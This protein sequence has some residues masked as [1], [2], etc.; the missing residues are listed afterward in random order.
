MRQPISSSFWTSMPS[1]CSK[2]SYMRCAPPPVAMSLTPLRMSCI[3]TPL[4]DAERSMSSRR[5]RMQFSMS[6]VSNLIKLRRPP[7]K[8]AGRDLRL[9]R[10][11]WMADADADASCGEPRMAVGVSVPEA[12]GW[13]ACA[14]GVR[15][16]LCAPPLEEACRERKLLL[17][18]F[19]ERALGV[20]EEAA[21]CGKGV[22]RA[23]G[24]PGVGEEGVE[25]EERERV[26]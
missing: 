12:M 14:G 24:E 5:K 15:K 16:P 26:K 9:R 17:L 2:R 3:E 20:D 22:E 13:S 6:L 7:G 11:E 18:V 8:A 21:V 1:S 10:V 19:G 25:S 4:T 23:T